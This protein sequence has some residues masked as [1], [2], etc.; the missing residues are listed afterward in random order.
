MKA[1]SILNNRKRRPT[2][3]GNLLREVIL[4][5]AGLSQKQLA[6]QLGVSRRT[7]SEVVLEQRSV[8]LDLA[9]RLARLFNTTPDLWIG[10]QQAVDLWDT[11]QANRKDYRKIKPR[12]IEAA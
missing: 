1:K 5:A 2:H 9:V 12:P 6:E 11:I 4:P 8:T 10:M 7:V 3:P